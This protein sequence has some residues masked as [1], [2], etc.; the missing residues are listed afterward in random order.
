MILYEPWV[1]IKMIVIFSTSC[2][3]T[4]HLPN[5][6]SVWPGILLN[7]GCCLSSIL[8]ILRVLHPGRLHQL[9]IGQHHHDLTRA[10]HIYVYPPNYPPNTT[11][12]ITFQIVQLFFS[13]ASYI[14]CK[15]LKWFLRSVVK[16]IFSKT[17]M[18]KKMVTKV[19]LPFFNLY[20]CI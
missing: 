13:K 8:W 5:N 15:N 3:K 10:S 14:Y 19:T 7:E 11:I 6:S 9:L 17:V 4:L 1:D 18:V 20:L 16:L 2:K 12:H